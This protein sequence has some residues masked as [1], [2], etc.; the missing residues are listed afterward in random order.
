M[1]RAERRMAWLL[2][3]YD[4]PTVGVDSRMA[5]LVGIEFALNCRTAI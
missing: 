5:R 4:A 3:R 2:L 1:T